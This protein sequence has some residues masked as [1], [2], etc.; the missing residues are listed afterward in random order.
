MIPQKWTAWNI[1][2]AYIF[3]P[4]QGVD[5]VD[6]HRFWAVSSYDVVVAI[7][8]DTLVSLHTIN[9]F[10]CHYFQILP[11]NPN[12][13]SSREYFNELQTVRMQFWWQYMENRAIKSAA[14][15]GEVTSC[16]GLRTALLDMQ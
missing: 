4:F 14:V 2:L 8:A 1:S 12:C 15:V 11:E 5:E 7:V 10:F 3:C 13:T 9:R 6:E 16:A